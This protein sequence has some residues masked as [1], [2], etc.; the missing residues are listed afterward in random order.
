MAGRDDGFDD[1][2]MASLPR[3]LRLAQRLAGSRP[4]AE[5]IA[6]E[7]FARAF[8]R[9]SKVGALPYREAWVMRVAANLAID[10][11]RRRPPPLVAPEAAVDPTDSIALRATLVHALRALPD[12]QREAVVLRYLA[13][14]SEADVA[15]AL[16][17]KPGTVKS[18]LH[19][20]AASLRERLGEDIED[21]A[22]DPYAI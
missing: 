10:S 2:F 21:I 3:V 11:V 14:L 22:Y 18:H 20:A 9:W 15:V 19:R 6:A 7:A 13:D 5:E 1:F 12:H 17:V 16:G 4:T 8:A